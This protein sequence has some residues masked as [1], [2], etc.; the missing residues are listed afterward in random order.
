MQIVKSIN[1]TSPFRFRASI[2]H[3]DL[4]FNHELAVDLMWLSGSPVMDIIDKHTNYQTAVFVKSKAAAD[5]WDT[6][7][8]CWVTIFVGYPSKIRL[9][10]ETAFDSSAFRDKSSG[11]GIV[12]QFSAV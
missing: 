5:L 4:Q 7:R 9:E 3:Y 12:L 1:H 8:R 10:Y 2:P 11:A 6:F